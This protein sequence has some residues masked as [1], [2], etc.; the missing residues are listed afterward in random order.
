MDLRLGLV[1]FCGAA[2]VLLLGDGVRTSPE[3]SA[4]TD[5][6]I[7]ATPT[8]Y[9]P[10]SGIALHA[11]R[12]VPPDARCP[13]CGMYPARAKGWAAQVV[14]DN[15]DTQF[16]D[17]PLSLYEYLQDVGRYTPGR[18][19]NDIA[20]RYVTAADTGAWI[21]ASAAV[22]V[23]GS[24]A[25]GPMRAGNLPAFAQRQAA[26]RFAR[27]RGGVVLAAADITPELVQDLGGRPM[28]R[29]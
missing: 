4:P 25:V 7:V 6:C 11:P 26:Q 29:H 2:G 16:F 17:S 15:G 18:S 13:V 28:H 27:E 14:F 19:V 1:F 12:P 23:Q 10:A 24:D 9:D 21:E 3:V 8:R 20:A 22:Y 5:V